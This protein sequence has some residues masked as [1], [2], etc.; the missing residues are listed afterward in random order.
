MVQRPLKEEIYGAL[1][2]S[3][4]KTRKASGNEPTRTLLSSVDFPFFVFE[5]FFIY[6]RF[7]Q[8][9]KSFCENMKHVNEI[10]QELIIH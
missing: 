8:A 2:F 9:S 1:A 7:Q 4:N 6:F 3:P 10:S 5:S